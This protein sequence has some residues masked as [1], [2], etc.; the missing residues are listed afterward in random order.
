M[1][2]QQKLPYLVGSK[3]TARQSIWGWRHFQVIN[4]TK[5]DKWVFAEMVASCDVQVR[6]WLNAQQLSQESDWLPGWRSLEEMRG[7]EQI[8]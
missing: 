5:Q 3:W 8:I 1:S 7:K 4:R 6:F 2:K